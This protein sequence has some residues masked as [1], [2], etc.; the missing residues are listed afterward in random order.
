MTPPTG[1]VSQIAEPQLQALYSYWSGKRRGTDW[2]AR[3]D[4]RPEEIKPLLPYVML[5][6][7]LGLGHRFR[8]RLVGTDVA[9]GIDPTGK[10]LHEAVPEGSYR[11]HITAQ[12]RRGAAGPGALYNQS[13]YTYAGVAGP[14]GISRLFMPL[15]SDGRA[16]DMML[17]GQTRDGLAHIERSTWQANPPAVFERLELRLP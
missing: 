16:V 15:S 4:I 1:A 11:D 12:F 2:P 17:V 3:Q 14:R 10:L 9:F 13:S 6:D 5:V 7:V 8:F